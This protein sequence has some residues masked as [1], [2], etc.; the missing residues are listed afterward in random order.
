MAKVEWALYIHWYRWITKWWVGGVRESQSGQ[1]NMAVHGASFHQL[2][3]GRLWLGQFTHSVMSNSFWPHG[4]QHTR[5]SSPP[6]TPRGCSN[7][8]PS[9]WRCHPT[10]SSS[11]VPFSSCG[12]VKWSEVAQL[13]PTLFDPMDS[14]RPGSSVHGIFQATVLEW[15]AISFSRGSS[16]PRDQTR[17]SCIVDRSFTVWA[18]REIQGRPVDGSVDGNKIDFTCRKDA[19]LYLSLLLLPGFKEQC[20][21]KYGDVH[22]G[23]TRTVRCG[24]F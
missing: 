6:P 17:V 11:V 16:Q 22:L 24:V 21:E 3:V 14:S 2:L 7:S 10:I 20:L 9:S 5:L 13:C 18:T 19:S 12:S 4:L 15:I 8:S 23:E 1:V